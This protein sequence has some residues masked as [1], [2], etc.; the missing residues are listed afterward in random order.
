MQICLKSFDNFKCFIIVDIH[1]VSRDPR[2]NV[3]FQESVQLSGEQ[4]DGDDDEDVLREI[5]HV[6]HI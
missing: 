6:V 4:E 1:D 3:H 5:K 2:L